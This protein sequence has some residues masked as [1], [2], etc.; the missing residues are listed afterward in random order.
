[1]HTLSLAKVKSLLG[2]GA[3]FALALS[4]SPSTEAQ[5]PPLI[6]RCYEVDGTSCPTLGAT[7]ECT[8][9]CSNQLSCTCVD[10]EHHPF[11][12]LSDPSNWFWDCDWEC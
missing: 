7:R 6:L 10:T 1:M 2:V 12:P 4:L 11:P 5:K 3:V 8:D 9:V